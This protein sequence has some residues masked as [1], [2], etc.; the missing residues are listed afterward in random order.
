MIVLSAAMAGGAVAKTRTQ[1]VF[2]R[3][4]W[5]VRAI[6]WDDGSSACLAQVHSARDALSIFAD[7]KNPVKLQFFSTAWDF[8]DKEQYAGLQIRIDAGAPLAIERADLFRQS[9]L[10][11]LP[12]GGEGHR[13]LSGIEH[14]RV[15]HLR[16]ARGRRV[17]SYSLAGSQEALAALARCVRR[18][19]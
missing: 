18:L 7:R 19:H 13:I 16:D 5:E 9:A 8:G 6:R 1:V 3:G 11:D 12:A 4:D 15:L 14:G 10:F 2:A 17:K